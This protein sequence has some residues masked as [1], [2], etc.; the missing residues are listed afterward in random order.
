MAIHESGQMY[1]IVRYFLFQDIV[2]DGDFREYFFALRPFS[3]NLRK[4]HQ[5]FEMCIRD[6]I[7]TPWR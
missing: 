3:D 2:S 4:C 6:S 7:C 1:D 5:P